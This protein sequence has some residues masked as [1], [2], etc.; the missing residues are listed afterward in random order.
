MSYRESMWDR[1]VN[2][3]WGGGVMLVEMVGETAV[4]LR[5]R[6][7]DPAGSPTGELWRYNDPVDAPEPPVEAGY[8]FDREALVPYR[9]VL[10]TERSDEVIVP[11]S[12][13]ILGW[14]N[15]VAPY[16]TNDVGSTLALFDRC[17]DITSGAYVGDATC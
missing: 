3:A 1:I 5:L 7:T 16:P 8:V 17:L 4:N 15:A 2:V 6:V 12:G 11:G 10:S 14:S 13:E 9:F